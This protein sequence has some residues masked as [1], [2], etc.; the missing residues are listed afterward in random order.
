MRSIFHWIK[1]LFWME[2]PTSKS[3]PSKSAPG[4]TFEAQFSVSF[5]EQEITLKTPDGRE[6]TIIWGELVGVAIETTDEGPIM[7]DVFLILGTEKDSLRI[8]QGAQ[9]DSELITRLQQ[10]PGFDN[11][12][13]IKAMS[14]TKNNLFVCWEKENTPG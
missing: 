5:D 7:S 11:L 2:N 1:R 13:M 14:S 8:P 10:L 12:A 9:G 6:F 3:A 4:N